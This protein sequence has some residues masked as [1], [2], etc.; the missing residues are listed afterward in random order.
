M[1]KNWTSWTSTKNIT[2]EEL[3]KTVNFNNSIII[4]KRPFFMRHLY[5]RLNRKYIRHYKKYNNYTTTMFGGKKIGVLLDEY[6]TNPNNMVE[7]EK[8]LIERYYRFSPVIETPCIMNKLCLYME[9]SIKEIKREMN[10]K[11]S[12][13]NI[14]ILINKDI[15]FDEE[16]YN[17]LYE[18]YKWYKSEKKNFAYIKD[19]N[20]K[21]M[22]ST[23]EQYNKHILNEA[24]KISS[25]ICELTNLAIHICYIEKPN[26]NKQFAWQIFGE[27]IVSNV[28]SNKQDE[29]L[30]PFLSEVG[31]I[32]YLGSRFEMKK[33]NLDIQEIEEGEFIL[34]L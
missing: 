7:E 14:D 20:G 31:D 19:F 10:E 6:N 18:L 24:Y 1:P 26:D 30:I 15:I 21:E 22:F 12:K 33:I 23:L 28:F 16:K 32:E 2:D 29:I 4:D 27:G 3:L 9:S 11:N 34:D 25:N 17:K 8:T 13:E 5:S